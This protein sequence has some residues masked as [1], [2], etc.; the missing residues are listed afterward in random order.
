MLFVCLKLNFFTF[1]NVYF[2][3]DTDVTQSRIIGWAPETIDSNRNWSLICTRGQSSSSRLRRP[4]LPPV[5]G[6]ILT[7]VYWPAA[8][9]LTSSLLCLRSDQ[10]SRSVNKTVPARANSAPSGKPAAHRRR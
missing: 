8:P 4:T 7:A 3:M 5:A 6:S 9:A 2:H 1:N 10:N